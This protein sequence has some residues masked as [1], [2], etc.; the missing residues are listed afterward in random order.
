[1]ALA[2][3]RYE[4][5]AVLELIDEAKR[6][7]RLTVRAPSPQYFFG[8]LQ[9]SIEYL[10]SQRWA[11]L[12]YEF[13]APCPGSLNGSVV[14]PG[15]F[16]LSSLRRLH[17]VGREVV[18]CQECATEVDLDLLLSGFRTPRMSV[19]ELV[20]VIAEYHA[21]LKRDLAD[22]TATTADVA[23]H[24][25]GVLKIMSQEV[26]DCP[27]LFQMEPLQRCPGRHKLRITLWCEARDSWH[28]WPTATY[29]VTQPAAWLRKV[30][31][32]VSFVIHALR[33]AMPVATCV[34]GALAS[35][36]QLKDIESRLQVME[37]MMG[38]F[39]DAAEGS[40]AVVR[41]PALEDDRKGGR[42]RGITALSSAQGTG[43]VALRSLLLRVDPAGIFGGLRRWRTVE[44]DLVWLCPEHYL[45]YSPELPR[46]QN[47]SPSL[48]EVAIAK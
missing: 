22:L 36:D 14:C 16:K 25:R 28:P 40:S 41:Q 8:I 39:R 32:Y 12:A 10:A 38:E 26:I 42:R 44:N 31:P 23:S 27:R 4:S 18:A 15:Q 46:L 11:G 34:L 20:R 9:D 35:S 5:E 29:T 45:T 7:L 13:W 24:L 48:D 1:M 6:E 43:L 2:Y 37:S 33:L 21:D 3:R 19:S 30:A 47:A 17:E